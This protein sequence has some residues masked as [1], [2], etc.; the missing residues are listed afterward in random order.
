MNKKKTYAT[1]FHLSVKNQNRG[2]I[3]FF[4]RLHRPPPLLLLLFFYR[5]LLSSSTLPFAESWWASQYPPTSAEN[6]LLRILC[7][8]QI[9]FDGGEVKSGFVI[10]N[11]LKILWLLL[12]V[13]SR[14]L[15]C[16][17]WALIQIKSM[18]QNYIRQL[19]MLHHCNVDSI[20]VKDE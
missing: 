3:F 5:L 8:A 14:F 16:C 6:T 19:K 4:G 13:L 12:L 15:V 17:Y 1:L 9:D 7:R 11:L 18:N 2:S 20:L 10:F